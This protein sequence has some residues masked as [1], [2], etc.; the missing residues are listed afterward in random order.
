MFMGRGGAR[1]N[2]G[3][4]KK[5]LDE[6]LLNGNPGKRPLKVLSFPE[7]AEGALPPPPEFLADLAKGVGK[8]PNAE[9]I[10]ETVSTWLEKTGCVT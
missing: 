1:K 2:A 7:K 8:C 6:K 5:S 3:R 10:F 9:T 4:P